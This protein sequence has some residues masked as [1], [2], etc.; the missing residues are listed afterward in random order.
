MISPFDTSET[1][2]TQEL[3]DL[4]NEF[5]EP[6]ENTQQA[7]ASLS[8]NSQAVIY[9][10][11]ARVNYLS[12]A[13]AQSSSYQTANMQ[14]TQTI[15]NTNMNRPNNGIE[16]QT[17]MYT[18]QQMNNPSRPVYPRMIV[19]SSTQTNMVSTLVRQ[20]YASPGT[21][22]M[23]KSG[24]SMHIGKASDPNNNHVFV[25]NTQTQQQLNL[26]GLPM[27]H[28]VTST[29]KSMPNGLPSLANQQF[30]QYQVAQQQQQQSYNIRVGYFSHKSNIR[31]SL[32]YSTVI[33]L[34]SYSDDTKLH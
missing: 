25:T 29:N 14:S 8:S 11:Q 28:T 1:T 15:P 21:T 20:P 33:I 2:S 4:G 6:M 13:R 5:A 30:T 19:P 10:N 12:P 26:N 17:T 34:V 9:Q 31:Y 24:T 23:N 18:P 7:K 32:L 3:F 22:T 16:Q 27:Q